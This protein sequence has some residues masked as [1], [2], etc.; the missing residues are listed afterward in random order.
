MCLCVCA[1]ARVYTHCMYIYV[2]V[3]VCARVCIHIQGPQ[4]CGAGL[5]GRTPKL[6]RLC[7][8]TTNIYTHTGTTGVWRWSDGSVPRY[9]NW[10]LEYKQPGDNGGDVYTHTYT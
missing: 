8:L 4:V 9:T 6:I 5:T 7:S 3:C 2:S 10:N 1:L